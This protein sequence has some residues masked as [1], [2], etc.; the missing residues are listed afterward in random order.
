MLQ[1]YHL[2]SKNKC[3]KVLSFQDKC[4]KGNCCTYRPYS[5]ERVLIEVREYIRFWIREYLKCHSTMVILQGRNVV[6]SYCQVRSCIDL[7]SVNR[8]YIIKGE[9][10]RFIQLLILSQDSRS[11]M[12]YKPMICKYVVPVGCA[13]DT[14][15]VY[16]KN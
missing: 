6:I 14:Y 9:N 4:F 10:T 7:V 1:S 5:L 8:I 16:K 11:Y 15:I 3:P 2:I 13:M 12:S